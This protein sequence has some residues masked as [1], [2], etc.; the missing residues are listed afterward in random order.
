M[1]EDLLEHVDE[2]LNIISEDFDEDLALVDELA[3]QLK[4]EIENIQDG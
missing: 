1:I 3:H 2:I 4:E